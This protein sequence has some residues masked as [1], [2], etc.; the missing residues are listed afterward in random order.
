MDIQREREGEIGGERLQEAMSAHEKHESVVA[1][2]TAFSVCFYVY[3]QYTCVMPLISTK[4][5]N[6]VL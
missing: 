4:Y 2:F 5:F 1:A 6:G 3:L